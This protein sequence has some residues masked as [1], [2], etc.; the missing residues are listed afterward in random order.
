M[1]VGWQSGR[2]RHLGKVVNEQSLQGFESLTYLLANNDS[3]ISFIE[4][5]HANMYFY[6]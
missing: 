5:I 3:K 4:L 2:M 1:L 6:L